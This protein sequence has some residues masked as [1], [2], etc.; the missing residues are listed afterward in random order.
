M[1]HFRYA[2]FDLDGTLI[3]SLADLNYS[4]SRVCE[5]FNLPPIDIEVTRRAVGQGLENALWVTT[6]AAQN[7][8]G[9]KD[10]RVICEWFLAHKE[11]MARAFRDDYKESYK[12][13]T[14]PFT[15]VKEGLTRLHN[16]GITLLVVSNKPEAFCKQ[17]LTECE[18]LSFFD[19]V[20]GEDTADERKPSPLVGAYIKKMLPIDFPDALMVGDSLPDLKFG[21][22]IGSPV[23]LVRYGIPP[24]N[25]MESWNADYYADT[26]DEV[27]SLILN[28]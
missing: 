1:T 19:L 3:D 8:K 6:L 13:S 23:C 27:A 21:K 18:L 12:R 7:A 20:V 22:S 16:A 24:T 14:V 9:E 5:H 25:L 10:E 15:G 26:F 2:I 4:M 11:E 28:A 17:I